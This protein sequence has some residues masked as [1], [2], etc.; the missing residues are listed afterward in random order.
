MTI[1]FYILQRITPQYFKD[2]RIRLLFYFLYIYSNLESHA[3]LDLVTKYSFSTQIIFS[4][5]QNFIPELC[6]YV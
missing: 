6:K 4:S 2:G 5:T 3:R 1:L